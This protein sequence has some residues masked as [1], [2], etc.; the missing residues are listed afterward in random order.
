M[1]HLR[2]L[3]RHLWKALHIPRNGEH[4]L[5]YLSLAIS[6][7]Q[8]IRSVLFHL[9]VRNELSISSLKED[10]T[11]SPPNSRV[12]DDRPDPYLRLLFRSGFI[13]AKPRAGSA[14][15]AE[16]DGSSTLLPRRYSVLFFGVVPV[17]SAESADRC[18]LL[19]PSESRGETPISSACLPRWQPQCELCQND[20]LG[21]NMTF[22]SGNKSPLVWYLSSWPP[23]FRTK[24][25]DISR[26]GHVRCACD[27]ITRMR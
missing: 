16:M 6:H 8:I 4:P 23:L 10:R 21:G 15:Q 26:T 2:H 17:F 1:R 20:K 18:F 11:I 9:V 13:E 24:R 19:S 14:V 27:A 3:Q 12:C 25:R 7:F 5:L 22:V